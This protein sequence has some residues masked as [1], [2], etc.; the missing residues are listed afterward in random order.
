MKGV[1][2]AWRC[3]SILNLSWRKEPRESGAE[4]V[5]LGVGGNEAIIS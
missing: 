4:W 2:G 1:W 3:A 5:R